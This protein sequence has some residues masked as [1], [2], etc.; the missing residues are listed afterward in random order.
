MF[1]F[2]ACYS[3]YNQE[4]S[5]ILN[6]SAIDRGFFRSVFMRTYRDEE[7]EQ[8]G[9]REE[10]GKPTRAT[11][12]G[13]RAHASYDKI[14]EDGLV[15]PGVRTSGDDVII[16]K[17][18]PLTYQDESG[19]AG[20]VKLGSQTRRDSSTC[21]RAAETGIIDQVLLTNDE[22]GH[23]FAKV[24]VRSVRVPQIGDKFASRHGQ[25]GTW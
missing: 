15:A 17:T 25:K 24:R 11:T 20:P 7:D 13:M 10:F 5:V 8:G 18:S 23:K 16:G 2:Q 19:S 4:D 14:D 21:Q 3:G 6:Q 9:M 1:L 12:A 22:K